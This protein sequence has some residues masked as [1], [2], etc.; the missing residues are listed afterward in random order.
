M[1][2]SRRERVAALKA[3]SE[4]RLLALRAAISRRTPLPVLHPLAA[5]QRLQQRQRRQQTLMR[6]VGAIALLLLGLLLLRNCSCDPPPLPPAVPELICPEAP[7][8]PGD[9]PKITRPVV[10]KPTR[11]GKL[12]PRA[13]DPLA[14]DNTNNPSW[15][16][17][18]RL[19]VSARSLS[20]SSCFNGVPKPGALRWL[21]RVNATLGTVSDGA[22][23]PV[24]GSVQLSGDQRACVLR[25]LSSQPYRLKVADG[26]PIDA[27]VS[28]V[29]EF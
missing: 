21:T 14:I 11:V 3:S 10:K 1:T 15:L 26:D 20:L 17:A 25:T 23:E 6:V 24:L 13:R 29:L 12:K 22:L 16:T 9:E 4:A 19:Q 28:L 5:R 27:R 2:P 18:F 8:C 7:V